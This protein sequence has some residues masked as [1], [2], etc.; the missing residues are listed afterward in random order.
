MLKQKSLIT[1]VEFSINTLHGSNAICHSHIALMLCKELKRKIVDQIV[2][3]HIFLNTN[4]KSI[5]K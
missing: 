4:A 2:K 1:A 5:R 3:K